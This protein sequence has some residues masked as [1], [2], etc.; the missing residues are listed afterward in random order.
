MKLG[1]LRS[2]RTLIALGVAAAALLAVAVVRAVGS[3]TSAPASTVLVG[4]G[5]F[6]REVTA[7]GVLKAVKATPILVPLEV[8]RSQQ[9]AWLAK[10]GTVVKAGDVVVRFDAYDA[11]REAA[12]GRADLAAARSRM[13]KAKADGGKSKRTLS[14]DQALALDE[15]DRAR[16]FELKDAELYSRNQ[17][18]E[19]ALDRELSERKTDV[20]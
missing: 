2:R 6:V 17:I 16:T 20:V 14:I 19:S 3:L 1:L 9:V 7:P 4:R 13:D 10:D 11:E 18:V 5:R 15:R 8:R 12:D